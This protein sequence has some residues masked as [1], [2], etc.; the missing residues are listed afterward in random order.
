MSESFKNQ[1]GEGGNDLIKAEFD[2]FFKSLENPLR[3]DSFNH[4]LEIED[5]VRRSLGD[6]FTNEEI[7]MK[8][9]KMGFAE[10]GGLI[11][12]ISH[13]VREVLRRAAVES[14]GDV[15]AYFR[16]LGV[17]CRKAFNSVETD[18]VKRVDPGE[19][20][21]VDQ[22]LGVIPLEEDKINILMELLFQANVSVDSVKAYV[23][24]TY[25]RDGASDVYVLISELNKTVIIN[26]NPGYNTY[27]LDG[28]RHPD[29]IA[30]I[31]RS[32]MTEQL[33][34]IPVPVG[35]K[36]Q[37]FDR[38]RNVLGEV[39][40]V[41]VEVDDGVEG[42]E[43]LRR[44]LKKYLLKEYPDPKVLMD[45]SSDDRATFK[46]LG[47]GIRN[48]TKLVFPDKDLTL[49]YNSKSFAELLIWFYGKGHECIDVEFLNA[50]EWIEE[51]K[52][53][54]PTAESFMEV[55][56]RWAIFW[57][58]TVKGRSMFFIYEKIF[59]SK[60]G[61]ILSKRDERFRFAQ[62]IYGK[63]NDCI[64]CQ[65]WTFNEWAAKIRETWPDPSDF[66]A[67]RNLKRRF[68]FRGWIAIIVDILGVSGFSRD[69]RKSVGKFALKVYGP[70]YPVIDCR[71]WDDEELV[72][73]WSEVLR[74]K[75]P[76]RAD[77]L[78]QTM[79]ELRTFEHGPFKINYV[80][81]KI[82]QG[83]AISGSVKRKQML[84]IADIVYAD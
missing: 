4:V 45:M 80:L 82:L 1:G 38:F 78:G 57:P 11:D 56:N 13:R 35:S 17:S 30:D 26:K 18:G 62:A 12:I 10:I 65:F 64:D 33:G 23:C 47:M 39:L 24:S 22:S 71:L 73:K 31:P 25:L 66:I 28:L 7:D 48:I 54:Y 32:K 19:N 14:G 43:Y 20:G 70:G 49:C 63:G 79:L 36:C 29:E 60:G 75:Y 21:D 37:D 69:D 27:V 77:F 5:L 83:E 9:G 68:L 72:D 59:G 74:Q 2:R 40:G 8:L 15:E 81:S 44:K 46:V 52:K 76:T 6:S 42:S 61:A 41:E 16:L 58:I 84:K 3:G 55:V 34:A 67:S 50:D 51:V 53:I